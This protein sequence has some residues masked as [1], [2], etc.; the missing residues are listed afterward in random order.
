M[1]RSAVRKA[2]KPNYRAR[3]AAQSVQKRGVKAT[4]PLTAHIKG[5]LHPVRKEQGHK[6]RERP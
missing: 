2:G 5:N 4:T 6:R 1:A 3:K